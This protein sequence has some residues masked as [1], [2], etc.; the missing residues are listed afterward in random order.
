LNPLAHALRVLLIGL[1][2]WLLRRDAQLRQKAADRVGTQANPVSLVDQGANRIAR[3]QR[4]GEVIL[5]RVPAGHG[6]VDPLDHVALQLPGASASLLGIQGIPATRPV[7]RQP[8]VNAGT[9][10]PQ[11]LHDHLR[12]LAALHPCDRTLAKL[13]QDIMSELS[14]IHLFHGR[15][16]IT[17]A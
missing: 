12:A 7:L 13:G 6:P 16:S 8:V 4:K 15:W 3:P 11:G 2:Q 5:T 9:G 17:S 1:P 14:A 10:K